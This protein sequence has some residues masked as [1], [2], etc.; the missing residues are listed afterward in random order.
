MSIGL[1]PGWHAVKLQSVID[2]T[3]T[4]IQK[5]KTAARK[6]FA[7]RP[8]IHCGDLSNAM[9]EQNPIITELRR[10]QQ[11]AEELIR[12]SEEGNGSRSRRNGRS[13]GKSRLMKLP[14]SSCWRLTSSKRGHASD[15][16]KRARSIIPKKPSK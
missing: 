8:S 11:I 14:C 16:R 6:H 4:A 10:V 7:G 3:E 15:C 2:S 12:N 13:P 9:S 1:E 5:I